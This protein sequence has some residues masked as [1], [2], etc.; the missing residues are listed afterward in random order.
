MNTALTRR[1]LLLLAA[2][3]TVVALLVRAQLV[4]API[5]GSDE[6]A[7]NVLGRFPG[8]DLSA[9]DP[10]LQRVDNRLTF[11]LLHT[12]ARLGG[13][14]G[15]ALARLVHII[16]WTLV[17]ILLYSAFRGVV[18]DAVRIVASLATLALPSVFYAMTILPETDLVFLAALLGWSM[19]VL[20]PRRPLAGAALG[21]VVSGVALLLKPHAI[22][23]IPAV[24]LTL[25]T[26]ALLERTDRGLRRRY[27]LATGLY[28]L[29]WYVGFLLTWRLTSGAWSPN[30]ADALGLKF[31]GTVAARSA[32][33]EATVSHVLRVVG[34]LAGHLVVLG[35]VFGPALIAAATTI[36]HARARG[37]CGPA[38]FASIF[39]VSMLVVHVGMASQFTA[40]VGAI[41]SGEAMRLHGR[42]LGV[43]LIFLPYLYFHF[44][45]T[46]SVAAAR[47]SAM[48][49]AGLLAV[50]AFVVVPRF[51][52]FPWD[53]PELF[54][55]FTAPNHYAWAYI[56]QPI[57]LG[58]A[59]LWLCLAGFAVVAAKPAWIRPVFTLQLIVIFSAGHVQVQRWLNIH[60]DGVSDTI[61]TGEALGKIL[62]PAA[63]GDG[64]VVGDQRYGQMSYLLFAL[65]NAPRVLVKE[66]GSPI[67]D[68]DVQGVK[69]VVAS[70]SHDAR[71]A[72]RTSIGLGEFVLYPLASI[73]PTVAVQEKRSWMGE[74]FHLGLA[75]GAGASSALDGFNAQEEWGAWTAMPLAKV[76]LP[77]VVSGRIRLTTFGWVLPERIDTPVQF[78]LG[79]C[80]RALRM[81]GTGTDY[82]LEFD[83]REATDRLHV[84]IPTA[85]PPGSSRELGVALR[86]LRFERF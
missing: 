28:L 42:Y 53:Y 72:H 13:G 79:D 68:G 71:F 74:P 6:Y 9:L 75:A 46:A 54:A 38:G 5:M 52:I 82:V 35:L 31:Y 66:A 76:E 36:L 50:F 69:W 61:R 15:V 45:E 34:Y 60:L 3:I 44:L 85:R 16:E 55:F 43:V 56:A 27:L 81:T 57:W 22:A 37:R 70:R 41:H 26:A 39:V 59:L 86:D 2:G 51:K 33:L 12:W 25:A 19:I 29:G 1:R 21:G 80:T 24:L 84:S 32:G 58:R 62:A 40:S 8:V 18:S 17:S 64:L 10:W 67:L 49:G 65:G 20:A 11:S 83:V 7:F 47:W 14:S 48:V 4:G 30:P 78:S 63:P 73:S 77:H 23:W